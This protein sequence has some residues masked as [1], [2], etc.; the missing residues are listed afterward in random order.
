MKR[1]SYTKLAPLT[2]FYHWTVGIFMIISLGVGLYLDSIPSTVPGAAELLYIHKNAGLFILL[3]ATARILWRYING[4]FQ[5]IGSHKIWET[6]TAYWIHIFLL[7]S[8]I[9]MPISGMM[10]VLGYDCSTCT[11]P[12]FGLFEI[13]PFPKV[14]IISQ[15]G[16]V[17]HHLGSKFVI[18]AILLHAA[19]ALKHHYWDGDDSLR[20]MLGK[21]IQS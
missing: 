2:L 17:I 16:G 19:A 3:L 11:L 12:I 13:G 6:K 7:V 9:A 1:D 14:E 10:M 21:D 18:A 5:P 4:F 20:R 15:I 8:T